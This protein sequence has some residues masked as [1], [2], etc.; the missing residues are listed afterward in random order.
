[1][2]IFDKLNKSHLK[3][4]IKNDIIGEAGAILIT[5]KTNKQVGNI[6]GVYDDKVV[7]KCV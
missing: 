2:N 5:D 7:L 3:K 1:M 6:I 4:I